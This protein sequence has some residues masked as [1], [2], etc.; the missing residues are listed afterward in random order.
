[1]LHLG[2][3][4]CNKDTSRCVKCGRAPLLLLV[5]VDGLVQRA[6][7]GCRCSSFPLCLGET[8]QD[9]RERLELDSG[10]RRAAETAP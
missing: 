2:L 3:V 9:S 10:Y 5:F 4:V 6:R 8:E 7:C 1:M